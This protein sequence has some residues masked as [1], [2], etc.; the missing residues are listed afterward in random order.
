[1]KP[2]RGP[3]R[4]ASARSVGYFGDGAERSAVVMLSAS[5][6][7]LFFETEPDGVVRTNLIEHIR[8]PLP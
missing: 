2:R 1:M 7:R 8:G 4:H 5:G 3:G 6:R